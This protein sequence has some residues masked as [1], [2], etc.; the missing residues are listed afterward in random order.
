MS[1]SYYEYNLNGT[2]DDDF[3]VDETTNLN[4]ESEEHGNDCNTADQTT[5]SNESESGS[6]S[7]YQP[8]KSSISSDDEIDDTCN[9][10]ENTKNETEGIVTEITGIRKRKRKP[11]PDDWECN[12]NKNRRELGLCLKYT[13]ALIVWNTK[14]LM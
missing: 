10:A 8:S 6:D 2:C 14:V 11:V 1:I 5:N 9:S 4:A 7:E 12:R 3:I 13:L